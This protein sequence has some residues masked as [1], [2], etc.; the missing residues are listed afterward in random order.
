MPTAVMQ[1]FENGKPVGFPEIFQGDSFEAV[2]EELFLD[3]IYN[4]SALF[5]AKVMI[6]WFGGKPFADK[7]GAFNV[8]HY[9]GPIGSWFDLTYRD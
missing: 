9:D 3:L 2:T 4:Y 7:V 6:K 1:E 8:R 5:G